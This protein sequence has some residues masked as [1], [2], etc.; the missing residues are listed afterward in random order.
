MTIEEQ[1]VERYKAAEA[2][3]QA[4]YRVSL[5]E[6]LGGTIADVQ[7]YAVTDP[8]PAFKLTKIVFSDGS[9]IDVEGEH[10]HPYVVGFNVLLDADVLQCVSEAVN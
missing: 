3:A 9:E 8:A 4:S 7:G 6:Y 5:C 10:D 2:K 1:A